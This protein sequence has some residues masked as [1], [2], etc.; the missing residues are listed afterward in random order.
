MLPL[1]PI[2][3]TADVVFLACIG[4]IQNAALRERLANVKDEII[5]QEAEF[6]AA[7]ASAMFYELESHDSVGGT[8]ARAE[9][10]SVYDDQMV[11]IGSRG[12][13][14]YN[15]IMALAKHR[16]CPLCAFGQVSTLDHYMPKTLYPGLAVCPKNLLPSCYDCNNTKR[17]SVP[18]CASRQTL[19]PY[20]D[21]VD[22]DIWLRATFEKRVPVVVK[23]AVL[24]PE[25]WSTMTAL[26]VRH[27]FKAFNLARVYSSEAASE[28]EG[29]KDR[30]THLLN[31]C[32]VTGVKSHLEEEAK[33]RTNSSKNS[34]MAALYRAL[35]A[36]RWFCR[37]GCRG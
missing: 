3:D 6:T 28:L 25:S 17:N 37:T 15:K 2:A 14:Y 32:G 26:R 36:S 23:F 21:N 29:I 13:V 16:R 27:H 20:Y 8:V 12:R 4:R 19:N 34:W 18:G 1:S 31:K 30:L 5:R 10:I 9:M 35:A 7:A 11:P 33:S 22:G 24:K